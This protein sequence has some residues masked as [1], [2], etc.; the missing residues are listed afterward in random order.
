MTTTLLIIHIE[1][2][3]DQMMD[4]R[5]KTFAF[6]SE[7]DVIFCGLIRSAIVMKT[8]NMEEILRPTTWIFTT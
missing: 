1:D 3:I 8:V 5:V 6:Q 4:G 2:K 7:I